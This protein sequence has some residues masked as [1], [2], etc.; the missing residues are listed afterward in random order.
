MG[1]S[2]SSSGP[3]GGVPLVPPWVP[4]PNEPELPDQDSPDQDSPDQGDVTLEPS[5]VT[6]LAPAG[7]FRAA[8]SSLGKY[9]RSGDGGQLRRA[10]G[11]YTRTGLGG[12]GRAT[13]RM[14]RTARDAGNLYSVL[15][16]LRE[17]GPVP[18]DLGIDSGT[19]A[20]LPARQIADR[21]AQA[22]SPSDGTLDAEA[23]RESIATAL[24]EVVRENPD[25]DLASM[26]EGQIELTLELFISNDLCRRVEVDVG[27]AVFEK[28]PNP[29]TAVR[30]LNEIYQFIKQHVGASLR[31]RREDGPGLTRSSARSLAERVIRDTFEIF[32]GYLR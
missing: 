32:E 31:R 1:T 14:G 26:D 4:N 19:L 30:R 12:A 27:K 29:A 23:S 24:S 9:A 11:H 2:G 5:R 22:L 28:A 25:I 20:G 21:I 10:L 15:S 7:R 8:R 3:G 6:P 16:A 17:G 18:V 13:Q